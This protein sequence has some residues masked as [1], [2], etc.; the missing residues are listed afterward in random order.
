MKELSLH[1]LDIM[2]NSLA[3]GAGLVELTVDE[4]PAQDRLTITVRDDGRGMTPAQ[5]ARLED[6]FFT[7]RTTRRVG[8]GIPLYKQTAQQTGGDVSVESA[9][10]EGTLVTAWFTLSHLDLPPMG[11]LPSTVA[12]TAASHPGVRIVFTFR[13]AGNE[14]SLDTRE[15]AGALGDIPLSDPQVITAVTEMIKNNLEMIK[16]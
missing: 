6:P 7:S 15:L 10:G 14:W 12:M 1:I 8:L 13:H 2:E 11:D 3:A 4:N 5:V 16:S 9:P